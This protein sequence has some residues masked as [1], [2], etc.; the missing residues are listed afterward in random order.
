MMRERCWRILGGD[1]EVDLST[2][3]SRRGGVE[4]C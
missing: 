4:E 2:K 3:T 1:E